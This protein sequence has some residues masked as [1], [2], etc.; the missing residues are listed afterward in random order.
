[1][2]DKSIFDAI[3]GRDLQAVSNLLRAEDSMEQF[4]ERV[5]R[6]VQYTNCDICDVN[7]VHREM[8]ASGVEGVICLE[9][10]EK[11]EREQR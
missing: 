11:L 6:E 4:V 2:S 9:C 8:N 5:K 10:D 1:M 3:M 7:P